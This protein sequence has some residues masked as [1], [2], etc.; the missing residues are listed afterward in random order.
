METL[1]TIPTAA[2]AIGCMQSTPDNFITVSPVDCIDG[3]A[4]IQ[5]QAAIDSV[6]AMGGGTVHIDA[7]YYRTSATIQLP[8]S[9]HMPIDLQWFAAVDVG[10]TIEGEGPSAT[11]IEKN[12]DFIGISVTGSSGNERKNIIIRNLT[13]TRNASDTNNKELI[14]CSFMDNSSISNI[15]L[16]DAYYIGLSITD[17]D[18]V[19]ITDV[20]IIGLGGTA[21]VCYGMITVRSN[22]VEFVNI[23]IDGLAVEK[24]TAST[25]GF[26][27]DTSGD[28]LIS[29][30]TVKNL[31]NDDNVAGILVNLPNATISNVI[32]KDIVTSVVSKSATGMS[33]SGNNHTITNVVIDTIT[34]DTAANGFGVEVAGDNNCLDNIFVT[35]CSGTGMLIDASADKTQITSARSTSNG[36]NFTDNGTN[37]TAIIEDS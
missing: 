20:N 9:D 32:I 1:F 34:A 3:Q 35:G 6:Y 23:S 18:I 36:T 10:V 2:I 24:S 19:K 11:I 28:V 8:C 14:K 15:E 5:I 22:D 7:G 31:S 4:D 12:G 21:S 27:I 13:V 29:N 16:L 37:T 17:S 30:I 25:R 33:L 26:I